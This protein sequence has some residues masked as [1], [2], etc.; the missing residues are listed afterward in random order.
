MYFFLTIF[1]LN[2]FFIC[3]SAFFQKIKTFYVSSTGTITGKSGNRCNFLY[4]TQ[5]YATSPCCNQSLAYTECCST[6]S[7]IEIQYPSFSEIS[8]TEDQCQFPS[9]V[10]SLMVD[11]LQAQQYYSMAEA[12]SKQN[13]KI[14]DAW[15]AYSQ[16]IQQCQ[17]TLTDPTTTCTQDSQCSY[18]R[19][20]N[21][22]LGTCQYN[23]IHPEKS[24]AACFIDQMDPLILDQMILT[25]NLNKDSESFIQDYADKLVEFASDDECVG[26]TSQ[27]C[28]S[29]MIDSVDEYGNHH[30]TMQPANA[31]CCLLDRSCNWGKC[32]FTHGPVECM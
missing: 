1:G 14:Q 28:R 7:D 4:G 25:W 10:E 23:F 5:A 13:S 3:R 9:R 15:N 21:L 27:A 8:I 30:P 31:T 2:D 18:F 19:T 32:A 26:P 6:S 29:Q 20:C 17:R 22:Q 24:L 16:F 11:F 12:Q